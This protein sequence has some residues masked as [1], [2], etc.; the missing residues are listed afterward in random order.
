[1]VERRRRKNFT[2]AEYIKLGERAGYKCAICGSSKKLEI[3]HI[4]PVSKGGSDDF[5]NLQ[6]LCKSCNISKSDKL[7]QV[8]DDKKEALRI[9]AD[10]AKKE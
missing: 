6:L 2:K 7:M 9:F 1:M 3:D 4:H 8:D 5:E 10:L